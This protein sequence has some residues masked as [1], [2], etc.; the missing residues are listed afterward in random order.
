MSDQISYLF[1][2]SN[3]FIIFP[4]YHKAIEVPIQSRKF[5]A[6]SHQMF[7]IWKE[8]SKKC[9]RNFE[10]LSKKKLPCALYFVNIKL[11]YAQLTSNTFMLLA[12]VC[13][14]SVPHENNGCFIFWNPLGLCLS[15]MYDGWSRSVAFIQVVVISSDKIKNLCNSTDLRPHNF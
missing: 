10:S 9:T 4:I 15:K 3:L 1:I 8:K 14:F 12:I 11:P 5:L 13:F 6:R 7:Y 2:T